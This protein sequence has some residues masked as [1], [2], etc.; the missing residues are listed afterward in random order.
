MDDPDGEHD[1]EQPPSP[2][3]STYSRRSTVPEHQ[4]RKRHKLQAGRES[5]ARCVALFC[6]TCSLSGHEVAWLQ[7]RMY[8]HC[9]QSGAT[10]DCMS[11][12]SRHTAGTI[13]CRMWPH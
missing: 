11:P 6:C 12:A 5:R 9:S 3:G 4:T 1:H 13:V 2:T 8:L 7:L 10:L